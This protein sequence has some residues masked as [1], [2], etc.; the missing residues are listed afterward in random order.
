MTEEKQKELWIVSE[1]LPLQQIHRVLGVF[2][3]K[4]LA[5]REFGQRLLEPNDQKQMIGIWSAALD[6]LQNTWRDGFVTE[7]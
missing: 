2:E 5:E 3:T 7:K 6:D 4:E 1:S